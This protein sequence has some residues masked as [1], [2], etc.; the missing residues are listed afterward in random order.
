MT[1]N[2][3][4]IVGGGFGGLAAAYFLLKKGYAVTV[5]E[6]EKVLGGELATLDVGGQ[7]PVEKYYHHLFPGDARTKAL[8]AEL[9]LAAKLKWRQS[10]VGVLKNGRFYPFSTPTDLLRLPFLSLWTKLRL[11]VG[12][13]FLTHWPHERSFQNL[14]AEKLIT[15]LMGKSAW[16]D[17]WQS[18]FEL[19]FGREATAVSGVWFWRRLR[20]RLSGRQNG[21]FLGYPDGGFEPLIER[22]SQKIIAAG[23]QIKTGQPV[24]KIRPQ[25]QALQVNREQFD[26][27]IAAV[28]LPVFLKIAPPQAVPKNLSK[29][30]HLAALEVLLELEKPLTNYYWTNVLDRNLPFVVMTE[31]TNLVSPKHYGR[32]ILYL[33]RYLA[34]SD[35]LFQKT[36]R[37]VIKIFTDALF[38]ICP[39][40]KDSIK[41]AHVFRDATAQPLVEPGYQKPDAKTQLP[42]L[43]LLSAAQIYPKDRGLE[44]VLT[45]V[46]RLVDSLA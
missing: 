14:T 36:D 41:K 18:M 30:K 22:L 33:G 29:I 43:F 1:N 27:V 3:I 7:W 12:S 40:V 45:E 34:A 26:A 6:K 21:E 5:F 19:K 31:H 10:R 24:T 46:E 15:K 2:K 17:F 38:K 4:A 25:K 20:D 8:F 23:G 37:E 13:L 35:L 39:E 11:G 32:S 28:P 42:N 9:G 44:G 16:F